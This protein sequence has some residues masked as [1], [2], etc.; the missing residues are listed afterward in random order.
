MPVGYWWTVALI[1][2]GVACALT[3]WPRLGSFSAIPALLV[4]ELPF[5]VGYL[6][7]AST[8]LALADGD[9]DSPGGAAGAAVALLAL[10]G[11]WSW[12][13]ARCARTRRCTTPAGRGGRGAASCAPRSSRAGSTWSGCAAWPTATGRDRTLDVYHRRDRPASAPVLLHFHGGGFHSGNKAREARPL[14]RHLTSRRGFVCVSADYRL[15]PHVTLADQVAD[16]RDAIAWVRAHAAEYGAEPGTLFVAGSSAGANLA[17][18]AVCEGETGIAGL[19]CRYGYYGNLAPRGDLP[20]M[21]VVHGDKDM[22]IPASDVRA[23][24]ERVR[25]VSSR[26]VSYAELP[27]AHHDFDMFESIRSAAVSQAV[28]QFTARVST[29]PDNQQHPTRGEIRWGTG[30]CSSP[31]GPGRA[32]AGLLAATIWPHPDR[33]RAGARTGT[34]AKPSTSAA[35]DRSYPSDRDFGG[36]PASTHG[37]PRHVLRH[38]TGK[39]LASMDTAF[40]VIDTAGRAKRPPQFWAEHPSTRQ[41]G[42]TSS[43]SS[44]IPSPATTPG[45]GV[46]VRAPARAVGAHAPSAC[47]GRGKASSRYIP[48]VRGLAF[49]PES[50]LHQSPGPIRFGI[51]RPQRLGAGS[52]AAHLCKAAGRSVTVST[53]RGRYARLR[54]TFFFA[55]DPARLRLP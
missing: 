10:A 5:I 21:L 4:S 48:K 31:A 42:T 38:S 24:V 34:A 37:H 20:P 49:A 2:W 52:L 14:I 30:T 19:I 55:S 41:L 16:V 8:V 40:G 23:F 50:R 51:H 7:I 47:R 28:D 53:A 29:S 36:A 46:A 3:R 32:D 11:L 15:Q 44:T 13:A 43:T 26:P 25:A 54:A 17:I 39:R 12:R 33:C 9:L 6:L 27:G 45:D 22:R 18:R 35:R 1:S